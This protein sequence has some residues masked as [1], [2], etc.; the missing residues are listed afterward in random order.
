[1]DTALIAV[2]LERELGVQLFVRTTRRVELTAAGE[3]F[4]DRCVR[5]LSDINV[6]AEVTRSVAGKTRKIR[7]GTIYPATIGVLPAFL[8]KIARKYPDIQLQIQSGSTGDIIRNS[9]P[10]RSTSASSGRW[11]T[12]VPCVFSRWR[13]TPICWRSARTA[14]WRLSTRSAS[15]PSATL[16]RCLPSMIWPATLLIPA[17]TRLR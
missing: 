13:A 10:A 9:K 7:I 17:M 8:S 16:P 2:R 3:T 1:M 5:I 6:S 4:Y 15:T 14:G 11:K 12:S